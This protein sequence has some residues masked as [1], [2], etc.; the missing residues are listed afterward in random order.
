MFIPENITMLTSTQVTEDKV[1]PLR[2]SIKPS[3]VKDINFLN[4]TF[5]IVNYTG[6][7][8]TL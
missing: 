1:P 2:L 8:M 7:I 6:K 5:K 3:Y 4:F